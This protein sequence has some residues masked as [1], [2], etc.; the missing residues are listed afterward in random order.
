M[1]NLDLPYPRSPRRHRICVPGIVVLSCTFFGASQARSQ[2]VAEAAKQARAKKEAE[3]K[4]SKHVYTNDDLKHAV[5]LTPE[6]REQAQA[7]KQ[8]ND[9]PVEKPADAAADAMDA[10]AAPAQVSLGDVARENRKQKFLRQLQESE[11]SAQFHLPAPGAVLASPKPPVFPPAK[12]PAN[13]L[14]ITRP[15]QRPSANLESFVHP[16]K[17][18]PFDRSMAPT[19][20]TAPAI[21]PSLKAP[22][23]P[24]ANSIVRPEA[25]VAP[26]AAPS[27]KRVAPT[28]APNP[29]PAPTAKL[30]VAPKA[31]AEATSSPTMGR[32]VVARQGDSLWKLAEQNLGRGLRWKDLAAANPNI[33]DPNHIAVGSRIVV[34]TVAPAVHRSP[35]SPSRIKVQKGDTLWTIAQAQLGRASA[36]GCIAQANP[37]VHDPNRILIGQ[38]LVIPASCSNTSH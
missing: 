13:S 10:Q 29:A 3:Q 11:K 2:D 32:I 1:A 26:A 20:P 22:A 6:D 16:R 19:A 28:V 31:A 33:D 35:A 14:V 24:M 9:S 7:K 5:I 25:P 12:A 21:R 18:S 30:S 8:G 15:P 38:E 37:L 4:K 34:P 17:R 23:A 27:V 36:W